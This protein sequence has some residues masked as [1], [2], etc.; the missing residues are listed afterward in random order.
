M[1]C[2]SPGKSGGLAM[3]WKEG[4]KI[5]I[6]NYSRH[7]IDSV[8]QLEDQISLRF[9]GFCGHADPNHR[10]ESWNML[11]RVG[12]MVNETWIIGGDFNA[13]VN[14][15]EKGGGR[16]KSRALM[17]EFCNVI[18]ELSLVDI[19]T[20][21]VWYIWV[22]NREGSIMVKERLDRFMISAGDVVN[23]PY[24][25]TKVVRQSTSDHGA[26]ILDTMRG[27][28]KESCR[29]QRLNFKYECWAKDTEAKDIIQYAWK[30]NNMDVIT[31]IGKVGQDL[32]QWQVNRNK[33]M[34][35]QIDK[36]KAKMNKI[37]GGPYKNN[38]MSELKEIRRKLGQLLDKEECY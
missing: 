27:K 36:L 34:R 11:K 29:D 32:G 16:R 8:I 35:F 3:L 12:G 14:E 30:N 7:H 4:T 17:D 38:K 2:I 1:D 22:N 28:P 13:I 24:I 31:K 21:K 20:V 23:F 9:T 10:N 33:R 25:E 18:E 15:T 26:I 19:K 5:D 6:Q 37:I